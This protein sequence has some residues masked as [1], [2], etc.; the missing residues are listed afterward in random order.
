MDAAAVGVLKELGWPWDR[1]AEAVFARVEAGRVAAERP[2]DPD[3]EHERD[4]AVWLESAARGELADVL[5]LLLR[6]AVEERPSELYGV[7]MA[8][9]QDVMWREVVAWLANSKPGGAE[10]WLATGRRLAALEETVAKLRAENWELACELARVKRDTIGTKGSL[11][12][13]HEQGGPG[14]CERDGGAGATAG[15]GRRQ[16]G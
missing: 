8:A 13:N 7:V 4:R 15:D 14:G 12:G 1:L 16:A 3:A 2:G 6:T 11:N 5:L 9:A 10:Q